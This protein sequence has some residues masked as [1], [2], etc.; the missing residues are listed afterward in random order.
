M[1]VM[2]DDYEKKKKKDIS[3]MRSIRDFGIGVVILL[4]GVFMFFRNRFDL[5][6]NEKY[7][8]D[9]MD[10]VMG[11]LCVAYGLWRLYRGYRKNYFK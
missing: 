9:V 5:A 1:K 6:I 7:P 11:G 3:L 8:P 2:L 10:K 4:F